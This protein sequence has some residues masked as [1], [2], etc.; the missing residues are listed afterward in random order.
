ML[1][2]WMI[3]MLF[4]E[5][6]MKEIVKLL[7]VCRWVMPLQVLKGF[8]HAYV[9]Q[10]CT[11]SVLSDLHVIWSIDTFEAIT[12]VQKTDFWVHACIELFL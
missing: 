2:V 3:I 7:L 9:T 10:K 6:F 4:D 11:F 1:Q 12:I 5:H 8:L